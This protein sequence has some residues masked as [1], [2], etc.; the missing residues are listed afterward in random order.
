MARGWLIFPSMRVLRV[1]EA[2]SSLATLIVFLGPSSVQYRLPPIQSTAIPSTV[3]IPE[4]SWRRWWGEKAISWTIEDK[5]FKKNL[6]MEVFL[7]FTIFFPYLP[8]G[9]CLFLC[10]LSSAVQWYNWWHRRSRWTHCQH[11]NPELWGSSSSR[12][13]SCTHLEP[14][15]SCPCPGWFRDDLYRT[16]GTVHGLVLQSRRF[17]WK[18][19]HQWHL[20]VVRPSEFLYSLLQDFPS[21]PRLN[22]ERQRQ[23]RVLWLFPS[24]QMSEQPPAFPNWSKAQALLRTTGGRKTWLRSKFKINIWQFELKLSFYKI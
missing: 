22:P 2:F 6:L 1:C 11:G 9:W 7:S 19:P 24:R 15:R 18:P 21:L 16:P 13:V 10:R 4:I 23:V 12:W 5:N 3:W 17:T 8:S 14:W 20:F